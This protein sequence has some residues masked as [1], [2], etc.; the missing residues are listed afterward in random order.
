MVR[1][2]Q[3]WHLEGMGDV[4]LWHLSTKL[5]ASSAGSAWRMKRRWLAALWFARGLFVG[6]PSPQ[7][8]R[9][10][11]AVTRERDVNRTSAAATSGDARSV[12]LGRT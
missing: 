2:V 4:Q 12:A 6:S 9:W 5:A 11:H 10:L 7:L 1:D 3:L 8:V